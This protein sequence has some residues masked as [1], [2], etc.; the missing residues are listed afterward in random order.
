MN[1]TIQE[2]KELYKKP[3]QI[4]HKNTNR[5]EYF[6]K[7]M[8]ERRKTGEYKEHHRRYCYVWRRERNT[9]EKEG[10]P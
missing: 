6:R 7:Y 10:Q 9:V 1:L 3:K 2:E 8:R 5:N 4:T